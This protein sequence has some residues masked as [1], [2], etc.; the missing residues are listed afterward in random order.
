MIGVP[1]SELVPETVPG[2]LEE[3]AGLTQPEWLPEL[4]RVEL[5]CHVAMNIPLPATDEIETVTV[6]PSIQV[7][8]VSWKHLLTL[9]TFAKKQ[10]ME[11]VEPGN[12]L[13]II[14]SDPINKNLRFEIALPDHLMAIKIAN[15]KISLEEEAL[16]SGLTLAWFD[17][18][19]WDAVRKGILL[20]PQ[21]RIRRTQTFMTDMQ[22]NQ[23]CSAEVF[24][25]QWDLNQKKT[26]FSPSID[27]IEQDSFPYNRAVTLIKEM[28]D[29]CWNRF[30]QPQLS[31]AGDSPLSHPQFFEIYKAASEYAQMTS[32]L[33]DPVSREE[34][35]KLISIQRP[36]YYQVRLEGLEQ[37]NDSLRGSGN[38]KET[39]EFLNL[40][41]ELGLPSMVMVNITRNN[42]DQIIPLAELLEG[43]TGT[44]TFKRPPDAGRLNQI[45]LT[46]KEEY[47]TF[48]QQYL[49]AIPSHPVLAS[50]DNL[51]NIIN[52]E[53]GKSLFG[54]CT[55]FGCGAAFNFI[56][57]RANGEVHACNN[58]P[59]PIG[60]I[61]VEGLEDIYNSATAQRY[62][63]G[64]S[65]CN[66]CKLKPVCGGCPAVTANLGYDPL[67]TKDPYCFRI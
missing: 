36:V 56:S 55:G 66:D 38:F 48:L 18:V 17:S 8:T 19:V 65:A 5:A 24:T 29:F 6:N 45:R 26:S 58:Y 31:F 62:R 50:K 16:K 60:N 22:D 57:I 39:V 34:L 63:E 53:Q 2:L 41:S 12:E 59:S 27:F 44:I 10:D 32:I 14:W 13:I 54:G 1:L 33:G 30:V 11:L 37:H 20:V 15:K 49:A 42:I 25:L 40:L 47:R 9:L 21:S 52:E 23:H 3:V 43:V 64:S 46:S 67:T 7:I 35:K 4:A 28:R 61:L 51:L